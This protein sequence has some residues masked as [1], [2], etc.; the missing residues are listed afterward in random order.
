[1]STSGGDSDRYSSEYKPGFSTCAKFS[2]QYSS[3]CSA[4]IFTSDRDIDPYVSNKRVRKDD[5]VKEEVPLTCSLKLRQY[6]AKSSPKDVMDIETIP[7]KE[8]IAVKQLESG[9]KCLGFRVAKGK[10]Q[11]LAANV[12]QK[13]INT[14]CDGKGNHFLPKVHPALFWY[15]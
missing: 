10:D 7:E 5:V 3:D 14:Q 6:T 11:V 12:P 1:L 9:S 2:D 4:E 8:A 15:I 13:L